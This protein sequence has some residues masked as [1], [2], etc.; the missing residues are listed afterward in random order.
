MPTSSFNQAQRD[1]QNNNNYQVGPMMSYAELQ[2]EFLRL[3]AAHNSL[4][5]YIQRLEQEGRIPAYPQPTPPSGSF[6]HI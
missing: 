6:N 3:A 2:R 4:C 5:A 1:V